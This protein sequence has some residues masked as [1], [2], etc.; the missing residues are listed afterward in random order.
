MIDYY[1]NEMIKINRDLLYSHYL[2]P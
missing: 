2:L 1:T